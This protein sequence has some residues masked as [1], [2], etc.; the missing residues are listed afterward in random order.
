MRRWT[1][2][3]W[4]TFGYHETNSCYYEPNAWFLLSQIWVYSRTWA[5]RCRLFEPHD[6]RRLA[7]KYFRAGDSIYWHDMISGIPHQ[8]NSLLKFDILP[9]FSEHKDRKVSPTRSTTVFFPPWRALGKMSFSPNDPPGRGS[10]NPCESMW[11]L[12]TRGS[13]WNEMFQW[14]D[15][16]ENLKLKI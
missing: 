9:N 3:T 14:V 2:N 6:N 5:S 16:R 11:I 15:L 4:K 8:K 13:S 12:N 10:L 7:S 1:K